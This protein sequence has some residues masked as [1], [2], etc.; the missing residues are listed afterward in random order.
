MGAGKSHKYDPMNDPA[1]KLP[2]FGPKLAL[3]V[4]FGGV[5]VLMAVAGMDSIRVLH[6]LETSHTDLTH[7]YLAQH[8]TIER[9]RST[10]Y[11]SGN[12]VRDYLLSDTAARAASSVVRL[13]E[14]RQEMR[15]ALDDYSQ[16]VEPA[17]GDLYTSL[18]E[19]VE[20]YWELLSPIADWRPGETRV[21]EERFLVEESP[22]RRKLAEVV[23]R[24]D[25]VNRQVVD[26]SNLRSMQLFNGFRLRMTAVL[27]LALG[28]GL[29]LAA[30]SIRHI[31]RLEDE[32]RVRYQE[33]LRA[34]AELERLSAK[35][36]ATQEEERRSI[37][38]ELHDEVGQS[39]SALLVDLGNLGAVTPAAD[40][41]MKQHLT[42]AKQLAESSLQSVRNMALLLRPSML[43]DFGLVPALHWQA[44]EVSRRTGMQ[45]RVEADGVPDEL[46]DDHKTCVYRV[47]QEALH[48]SAR[49]ASASSVSI[50][51]E[52][53][54]GRLSLT[55]RDDGQGFDP[56]K[57]RGMGLVGME[58]RVRHLGGR[59][60]VNSRDGGG[61]AISIELPLTNGQGMG[62]R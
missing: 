2:R 1:A 5:L 29:G 21:L 46:P 56:E 15:A 27:V 26:A 44:R 42:T 32:A 23:D 51:A 8:R 62:Q 37:S 39:L 12:A 38:R 13:R 18:E 45:V 9:I 50:V 11:L 30:F 61:T 6:R 40:P 57:I 59:F 52:H 14:L 34:R 58:E 22:H 41:E 25:A 47:V 4:G 3:M 24:I 54:A 43:D 7:T 35:L 33:I 60:E 19:E 16:Y 36:V 17:E 10:L 55:V 31:L 28:L 53:E 20:R 48:N 49:H